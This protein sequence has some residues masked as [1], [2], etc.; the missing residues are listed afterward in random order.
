MMSSY[1]EKL[2]NQ[3]KKKK[4]FHFCSLGQPDNQLTVV[5]I[6]VCTTSLKNLVC[7]CMFRYVDCHTRASG[8]RSAE[9]SLFDRHGT[10]DI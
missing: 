7:I 1:P 2:D 3:K 5:C 9:Q 10:S 8:T 4:K 6:A